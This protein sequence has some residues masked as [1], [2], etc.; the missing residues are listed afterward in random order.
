MV[1]LYLLAFC[2]VVI[3]LV[4]AT[5]SF[6]K[7][8]NIP[9]FQQAVRDFQL[10]PPGLSK[11]A[12]LLFLCGELLV[13]LLVAIG[14]P[15]LL[16]GFALAALLLLMFSGALT[17][18]VTR[19][20]QATCNCFGTSNKKIVPADIWRNLGFLLCACGGCSVLTWTQHMHV[21]LGAIE[22]LLVSLAACVFVLI[23]VQLGEIV[24]L[25]RLN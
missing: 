8:R 19:R 13:V 4:F 9:R 23:W 1:E 20:L 7:A 11:P 16:P 17:W 2:R 3:G 6:G 24:Q 21:E 14:G 5:S 18:V 10:L 15:F 25:F 12:A 22:W